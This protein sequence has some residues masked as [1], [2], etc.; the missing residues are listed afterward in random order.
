MKLGLISDTHDQLPEGWEEAFAGVEHILH[1]GDVCRP[2][3]IV[4]LSQ[5]APVTVVAGNN[6]F[7]P[8]WRDL[9]V[10][11]GVGRRILLHHIVQ[12]HRPGPML[13]TALRAAPADVVVFGHT[14]RSFAEVID[15][16]LFL[17]PG[18]AGAPRFGLPR[19]AAILDLTRPVLQ[20]E[21]I[22][23]QRRKS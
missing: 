18:S 20:P 15:G 22:T 17:N 23:F 13:L 21:F 7:F 19:S 16:V 2:D 4:E 5:V 8:G 14:H 12:P 11:E 3:I 10:F 6:D 9:E 1:A